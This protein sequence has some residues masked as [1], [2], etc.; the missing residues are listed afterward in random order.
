LSQIPQ[1]NKKQ[2][3]IA[4]QCAKILMHN[5]CGLHICEAY[6][7]FIKVEASQTT[8]QQSATC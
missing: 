6:T 7:L 2:L 3:Y 1:I 5:F 8:G 4:A